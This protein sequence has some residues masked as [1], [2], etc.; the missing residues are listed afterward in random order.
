MSMKTMD[1]KGYTGSI[2][3]DEEDNC[4]FGK[5]LGLPDD[6]AITYEGRNI[7][8]LRKDFEAAVDDYLAHCEA[9]GILPRESK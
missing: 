5:V 4:L 3:A 6:T 1:Y 9:C 8:E 7:D 2:E